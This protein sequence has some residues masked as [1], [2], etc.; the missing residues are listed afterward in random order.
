MSLWKTLHFTKR[1]TLRHTRLV[2]L[3][4]NITVVTTREQGLDI[5]PDDD[6]VAKSYIFSNCQGLLIFL[7]MQVVCPRVDF[8]WKITGVMLIHPVEIPR[9]EE[10]RKSRERI[11][12]HARFDEKELV[13]LTMEWLLRHHQTKRGR[14]QICYS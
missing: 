4:V 8:H 9:C 10:H 7:V 2:Y 5:F 13:K 1:V 12:P 3:N 11:V 6:Q 14:K